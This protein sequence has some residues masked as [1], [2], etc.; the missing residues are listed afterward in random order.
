M[1]KESEP[2]MSEVWPEHRLVRRH[3]GRPRGERPV[4]V[5]GVV[6][7][8]VAEVVPEVGVQILPGAGATPSLLLNMH[9][10]DSI[11]HT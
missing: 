2:W 9:V 8:D 7:H 10:R 6:P 3:L 11:I 1:A 5:M 4:R